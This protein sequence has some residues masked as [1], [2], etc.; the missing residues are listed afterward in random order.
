MQSKAQKLVSFFGS[1]REILVIRTFLLYY[2]DYLLIELITFSA[3]I[4]MVV[5]SGLRSPLIQFSLFF[6][7]IY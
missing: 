5:L 3:L 4:E 2:L 6:I 7:K 1:K